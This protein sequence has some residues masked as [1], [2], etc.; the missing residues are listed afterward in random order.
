[1]AGTTVVLTHSKPIPNTSSGRKE[2]VRALLNS[3]EG[4]TSGA[5]GGATSNSIDLFPNTDTPVAA[6]GTITLTSCAAA[7]VIEI[8]GVD[9]IAVNGTATSGNNEFDM[10]GNDAA[11]AT[12]LAAAIN[13]ST[14]TGIQYVVS[15]SASSNIV[16]VTSLTK[17]AQGN[18]L[19]IKTGG[20]RASGTVTYVTPSGA[21]TVVVNG[22]TVYSA[23]AG[24][25]AALT[26]AAAAAA[27]NASSDALIAGH[28][29]ALSR[30]GVLFIYAVSDNVRGNAITTSA[31]GTGATADQARL[32]GA[33]TASSDGAQATGT[34]TLTSVANAETCTINGV[35]LTAH[36]NTDANNQFR[37]DGD[38]TA[39]AVSLARCINTS[40]TALVQQVVATSS[41]NIVTV[42]ARRGGVSGNTITITTGQ[43]SIVVSGARLT[44]GAVPTS[45]VV[46]GARLGSGAGGGGSVT[47]VSHTF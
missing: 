8:N 1:M 39:D 41:T 27:I 33:T 13:A 45:V 31:T 38:D 40:T 35:T 24:A 47:K 28:V 37:I 6:S 29:K 36:T 11:D 2:V 9:F 5:S 20:V 44:T 34:F 46:S 18:A 26:A 30:S 14:S 25:T 23:T 22:V 43:A 32:A 12:A 21:Q 19:T 17:G 16:T 10:S 15:A 4:M 7:T 3:V 42:T